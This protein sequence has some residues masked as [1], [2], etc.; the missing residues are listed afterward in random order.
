MMPMLYSGTPRVERADRARE[1]LGESRIE[2]DGHHPIDDVEQSEGERT[3]ARPDLE[4]HIVAVDTRDV[5]DAA[6]RVGVMDE[7]LSELLCRTHPE[8]L[9]ERADLCGSEQGGEAAGRS[10]GGV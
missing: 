10:R 3:Q 2:F 7:V 6:H 1:A 5:H 4:H 9:R 8:L